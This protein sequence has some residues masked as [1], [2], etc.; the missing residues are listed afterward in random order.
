MLR[1]LLAPQN[2]N[3]FQPRLEETGPTPKRNVSQRLLA[4]LR[5]NP[6]LLAESPS[7]YW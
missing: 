5:R 1:A 3:D 7:G 4:V 2:Q 6:A